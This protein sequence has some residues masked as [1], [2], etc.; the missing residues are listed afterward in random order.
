MAQTAMINL[1]A[2]LIDCKETDPTLLQKFLG[3]RGLGAAYLYK[4]VPPKVQAFDEKNCIIFT[5]GPLNGTP[6]PTSS[7]Y[8]VTFK[9]P[10]TDAYGYA[11]AGGHFGP[12]LCRA[13]YDALIITGR[14]PTPVYLEVR[15]D[16][17]SILPADNFWRH[18]TSFIE[19]TLV[20]QSGGRVASI[21][22]AGENLVKIAAIINDG[23]RAAARTGP[24]AV[25]GSKNLKAVHVIAN[26]RHTVS[27]E[28]TLLTRQTSQYLSRHPDSQ[29]LMNGSTLYLM[30]IKNMTGDLPTKNHQEC[31]IPFI[32]ALN[33]Q[34]FE[35]YW[36][37]RKGCSTC[38]L[39]CS[40]KS[41]LHTS[42]EEITVEGP[43][44]ETTDAFGPLVYNRDPEIVLR[45]NSMCNEFG[46]DTI[47]TGVC[48][49]FAM[50]CHQ[51]GILNDEKY[52]LEWGDPKTILGL[53]ED[54]ANRQGL[55]DLLAEGVLRA[56]HQI[57]NGSEYYAMQVKGVEM[58]RQEPRASKSFGL[59]HATSNRG[60]D[61][62]YGLPTIDTAGLWDAARKIFPEEQLPLLMDS[63]DETYKADILEYG[64][65]YCAV[66][67]S[68]GV[69]KFSTAETYVVTVD[70]LAA[71]FTAMGIPYTGK[72][73]LETGERIVNLERL[74]NIR[75]GLNSADDQ[76]PERFTKEPLEIYTYT[77]SP[78]GGDATRSEKP[79][80]VMSINNFD[81]MLQRYY[82]LRGWNTNGKPELQ[83]LKRLDLENY[84]I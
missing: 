14:S 61:H 43:E 49:A 46:L 29:E 41:L 7:R 75:H 5:S 60:A 6:W 65:N 2:G 70:D 66:L 33:Q 44:Y 83:T 79:V 8:H 56:S 40:R 36:T 31:Q 47:S 11:N 25:M 1:T 81:A 62:L 57:G 84:A 15:E 4:L 82:H 76:L 39:R 27:Q 55:G 51:H 59:G 71:G 24:G 74:Y 35:K 12:E 26:N 16:G 77:P 64:E 80:A 69:C 72:N 45:A 32:D 48:I 63:T 30:N 23:G 38:P 58:P 10:E 53:I 13:G 17:I 54:I 22:Q 37:K 20:S 3:G 9:S 18:T 34:S 67:D 52:S 42:T 21:G 73:L 68:L 19:E 28:F 78:D 50:E